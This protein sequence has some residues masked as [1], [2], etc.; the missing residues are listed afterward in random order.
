MAG[1]AIGAGGT[2]FRCHSHGAQGNRR[3]ED[4]LRSAS[5]QLHR[6]SCRSAPPGQ[7][8]AC[9][10]EAREG[11]PRAAQIEKRQRLILHGEAARTRPCAKRRSD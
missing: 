8:P 7:L 1:S 4:A 3:M 5:E 9:L 6:R 2:A 10:D 11:W